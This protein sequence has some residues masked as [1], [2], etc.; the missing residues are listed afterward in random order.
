MVNKSPAVFIFIRALDAT[1][2]KEKV[3]SLR[4]GRLYDGVSNI[5]SSLFGW[6]GVGGGGTG[7]IRIRSVTC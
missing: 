3:E 1:I 5:S 7:V 6:G 2:P 4:T